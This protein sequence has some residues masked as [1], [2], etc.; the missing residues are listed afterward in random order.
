MKE[1][2]PELLSRKGEATAWLSTAFVVAGW[3]ILSFS[4]NP[5]TRAI[6]FLAI[7]LLICALGISLGNWMDRRTRIQIDQDGIHFENGVRDARLTWQEIQQ[8][9]VFPSNWGKKVRLIGPSAHFDFRTLGEVKVRGELKGKMGFTE[10]ELILKHILE[11]AN[12]TLVNQS[13][14][15]YYYARK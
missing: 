15:G 13:G 11:R 5:V 4:G 10:G 7:V 8:V 6:P 3:L 1:Y 9:Q 12:L 14:N 2:H